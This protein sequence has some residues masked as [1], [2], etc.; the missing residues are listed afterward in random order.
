MTREPIAI[1]RRTLLRGATLT[2]AATGLALGAGVTSGAGADSGSVPAFV[3]SGRPALTHGVQAGDVREGGAML[4]SRADRPS[5][6][7]AEISRD[8]DFRRA[9]TVRGPVVT[10]AYR[11]HR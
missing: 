3:R 11:S 5:R 10:T 6:L 2:S 9:V 1:G 7:V 4:W 8:A